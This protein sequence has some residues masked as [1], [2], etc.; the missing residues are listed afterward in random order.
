LSFN[1]AQN[2]SGE[3]EPTPD[4]PVSPTAA[5]AAGPPTFV[6]SPMPGSYGYGYPPEA[7]GH[8]YAQGA[9]YVWDPALSQWVYGPPPGPGFRQVPGKL[10]LTMLGVMAVAC[11]LAAVMGLFN[12]YLT[13]AVQVIPFALFGL[14]AQVGKRNVWGAVL[15]GMLLLLMLLLLIATPFALGFMASTMAVGDTAG[16]QSPRMIAQMVGLGVSAMLTLILSALV[17]LPAVRRLLAQRLPI[18]ADSPTHALALS[19]VVGVTVMSFGQLLASGGEPDVLMLVRRMPNVILE[20][21]AREMAASM[22][23]TLAWAI[24]GV[25][26][27]VGWPI[28]RDLR[29]T[30]ERLGLV[31]PS[32]RQVVLALLGAVAMAAL[33]LGVDQVITYVWK[34]TGLPK[35]DVEAFERMLKPLISPWGAVVIGLTAGL[36]EEAIVRGALQPRLGLLLPNLAFT[37]VHAFQYGFDGLLSVFLAGLILGVVRQR[38]NTTTAAIVHGTYDF[39]LVLYSAVAGG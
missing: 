24:P 6:H 14:L 13:A 39:I 12:A 15:A 11:A 34:V 5:P 31:K 17:A 37:G 30:L 21:D 19:L 25:M 23:F 7:D 27:T 26:M 20:V 22:L 18:D 38:S 32:R 3:A 10:W 8:A 33:F 35:T 36:Q 29:E 28:L 9:G 2:V 16:G 4:P 1:E